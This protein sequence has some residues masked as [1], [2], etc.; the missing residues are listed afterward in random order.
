MKWILLVVSMLMPG[1]L[2][3]DPWEL[4]PDETSVVVEVGYLGSSTLKVNFNTISGVIDFDERNP[5]ATDAEITVKAED[6]ET[7]LGFLNTLVRSADYL[8]VKAHDTITFRLSELVQTSK[9][10][11]DI[12]GDI[13]LLGVTRPITFKAKVFRYGEGKDGFEA[14][15][16][17]SGQVDR[18]DFGNETGFPQVAAE[19][20]IAIRLL[21]R[22][23]S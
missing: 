12:S 8:N 7:G 18:R 13:T 14:G 3:A 9:S 15:F 4:V 1:P 22:P 23:K 16:D 5:Q 6:L 21:M 10:T 20:P 19:L 2:L 11:A 17:L